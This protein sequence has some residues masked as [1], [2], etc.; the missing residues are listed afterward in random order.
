MMNSYMW[1]LCLFMI[2]LVAWID[3]IIFGRFLKC[4]TCGKPPYRWNWV[5]PCTLEFLFFLSGV[6]VGVY[7]R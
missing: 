2:P 4:E 3:Y 7:G 6:L 5:L 1:F